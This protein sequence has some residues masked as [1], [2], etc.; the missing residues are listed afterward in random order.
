S[1]PI[2]LRF[3]ELI[4]G[5]RSD[6]AVKV[7]GDDMD[8]LNDTAN[9]IAAVL[10]EVA[11]ASEVK[12]EQ[13]TGLPMLN[14][15]IDRAKATRYGLNIAEIQ[16]VVEMAIGGREAGVI[17]EGD[18]RFDLIVRMPESMRSDIEAISRLPIAL[19]SGEARTGA[20]TYIR[21]RE[22]ATMDL[23]PGPNQVSREDGKRRVVVSENVRGRDIGSFV[24]EAETRIQ[25]QVKVPA[26]YWT[27]WGGT[28]ENPQS[29]T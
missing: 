28:F 12:V 8:V 20:T 24:V 6:V 29:A 14:V 17:F 9:R 3:N 27:T 5:V 22:V 21:L 2:Q 7:F 1:Q 18:Q 26:G 4:S 11:G 13:T 19:P 23:V 10:Q 25:E 15:D 16:E